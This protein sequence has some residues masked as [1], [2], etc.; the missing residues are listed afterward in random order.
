MAEDHTVPNVCIAVAFHVGGRNERAGG[1]GISHLFEHMMFNGSRNYAPTEFDHIL[2]AG[3]GYSN[4]YT[5]N[6]ITFY[7]E[8]FNPELLDRVLHMEAD[9]MRWL[10]IDSANLEQERGIVKEERRVYTDNSVSGKMFEDLYAHAF[11]AHPY[12]N[13]VVGWMGDLDNITLQDARDYFLTYYAPNNA[14]MF[15]VGDFNRETLRETIERHFGLLEPQNSPRRVVDSEPSQEGEK[16]ITL[17]KEAELPA[18]AIGYKAAGASSSDFYSLDLLATILGRGQSSRLYRRLVYDRQIVTGVSCGV[19][20]MIDPGLFTLYAQ[21]QPGHT[22]EEAE[23]EIYDI[24]S[25]VTTHG[26]REEEV[27]KARNAALADYVDQFKT[28]AGI[29]GRMGFYEVVYGDYRK[30]FEVVDRY[31]AV[32]ASDIRRVA[33]TYLQEKRRSVVIL[34]PTRSETQ[35]TAGQQ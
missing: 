5:S 4:A 13:P 18:V 28:H 24:I 32:T 8:E 31:A 17:V 1:T 20:A 16:R 33:E 15:V 26:V 25:E 14:T 22:V 27:Q 34:V 21:M 10:R 6:D 11:V 3:G 23:K 2:E 12:Q 29:A 7:Y 19:D 30:A 35:Q 9:R